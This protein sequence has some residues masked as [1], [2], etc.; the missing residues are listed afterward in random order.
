MSFAVFPVFV[1]RLISAPILTMTRQQSGSPFSAAQCKA[2]PPHRL[3][4]AFGS[5]PALI[6]TRQHSACMPQAA[7]CSGVAPSPSGALGS[8]LYFCRRRVSLAVS[9]FLTALSTSCAICGLFM[10]FHFSS[11]YA[12]TVYSFVASPKRALPLSPTDAICRSEY[13]LLGTV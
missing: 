4:W 13:L 9:P 7:L 6:S 2:V 10:P 12:L 8:P 5:A 1:F 3:S 11:W